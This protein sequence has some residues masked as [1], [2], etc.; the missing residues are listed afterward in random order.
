MSLAA[1]GS[2]LSRRLLSNWPASLVAAEAE[3]KGSSKG[4]NMKKFSYALVASAMTLLIGCSG[5]E[6]EH[7][8]KI[9][10]STKSRVEAREPAEDPGSAENQIV[11]D[12]FELVTEVTGSTLYF[13]IDTDLPDNAAVMVSVSR[14]YLER[15]NPDTYSVAYFSEKS[16]IGKWKSK[17]SISLS[18][19]DWK[20]A[21]KAK[22][23]EMSRFGLGFD[24][25]SISNNI[26]V[27]MVVPINQPDP[28]FG[29]RNKNLLGKAVKDNGIRIVE[30][31][32][33]IDYPLIVPPVGESPFPNMNPLELEIG[34]VYIVSEQ[35]PL[36]P[37]LHPTDPIAAIQQIKQIPQGGG[38]KV[39]E[40]SDDETNPWYKVT[41]FDQKTKHIGIGW[42][43]STALFGQQLKAHK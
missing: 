16:T 11:C 7:K 33:E 13:F 6:I 31:E 26:S 28:K 20:T 1:D 19:E 18:S 43:N 40:V 5:E 39:I 9:P 10:N 22:Q 29:I 17:Q 37:A 2:G 38:F 21:L 12:R 25:A 23:E 34:Q 15:G 3:R 42:I 8:Q 14:S 30:D 36:M 35:T 24:V 41:A 4:E 32:I 27:S